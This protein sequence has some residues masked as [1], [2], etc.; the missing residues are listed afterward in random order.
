VLPS[1]L[2]AAVAQLVADGWPRRSALCFLLLATGR[3]LQR[4]ST[5]RKRRILQRMFWQL[6]VGLLE[7]W[8]YASPESA[9][10]A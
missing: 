1:D 9:R 3:H 10:A 4:A 5:N 7:T 6:A 8:V 2:E